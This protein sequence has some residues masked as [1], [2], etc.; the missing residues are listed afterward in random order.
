M[1]KL[2]E[3]NESVLDLIRAERMR[4]D[5]KWGEQNHSDLYWLGILVEEV[6]ELAKAIIENDGENG[7]KELV[8]TA[9]VCVAWMD[10]IKRRPRRE[11]A[12]WRP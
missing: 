9:A 2:S 3:G 4:Q 5:S 10:A 8:Q 1:N 6:G 7:V 11:G 12:E